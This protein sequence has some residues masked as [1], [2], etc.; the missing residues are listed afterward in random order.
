MRKRVLTVLVALVALLAALL[1]VQQA[2]AAR[3]TSITL[4]TKPSGAVGTGAELVVAGKVVGGIKGQKVSLQRRA[5]TKWT[6]EATKKIPAKLTF[7][8]T[9][10]ARKGKQTYRV[11]AAK[12]KRTKAST[13]KTFS[14]TGA[15]VTQP[16][17]NVDEL[18]DG[19]QG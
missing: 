8:F 13:S 14:V 7:R 17:F 9:W 5:G 3:A 10:S 15:T 11:T 1:P 12:T 18:P 6:T 2:A 4:R 16:A 19:Y